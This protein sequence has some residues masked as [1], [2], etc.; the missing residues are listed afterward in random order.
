MLQLLQ[1]L[2]DSGERGPLE[3]RKLLDPGTATLKQFPYAR[4]DVFWTDAG[5]GRQGLVAQEGVFHAA[6]QQV[7]SRAFYRDP[8]LWAVLLSCGRTSIG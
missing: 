8:R 7:G 6:L 1:R 5:E 2:D 3:R 4:L